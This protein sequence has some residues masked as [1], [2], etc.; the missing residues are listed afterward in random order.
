[1]LQLLFELL[2]PEEFSSLF[3]DGHDKQATHAPNV[4]MTTSSNNAA[5]TPVY[6]AEGHQQGTSIEFFAIGDLAI[7]ARSGR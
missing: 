5:D 6:K 7:S 2:D 4:T 3:T 1:M